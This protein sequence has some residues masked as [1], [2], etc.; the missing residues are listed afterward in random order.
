MDF[1]GIKFDIKA[2]VIWCWIGLVGG[3]LCEIN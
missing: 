3:A 2:W 1:F